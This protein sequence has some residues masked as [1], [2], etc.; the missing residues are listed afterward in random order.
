M[1]TK[2]VALAAVP[3]LFVALPL[4]ACGS[5]ASTSAPVGQSAPE[6]V[7][8]RTGDVESGTSSTDAGTAA[9]T[10]VDQQTRDVVRTAS[11]TVV[12][13][14]PQAAGDRI[15]QATRTAGGYVASVS[16]S[17]PDCG[18]TPCPTGAAEDSTGGSSGSSP[19][20]TSSD[21]TAEPGLLSMTVRVPAAK[22]DEVL[23][24]IRELG[25][26]AA[27]NVTADDVTAQTVDLDARIESQR[28]SVSRMRE[29]LR[30]ADTIDEM[31]RVEG[32]LAQRQADLES[33][34]SQRN[35]LADQ[36]AMAT[37]STELVAEDRAD[38]LLPP[39]P[40]W[41]DESWQAFTDSW[42]GLLVALAAVSPLLILFGIGAL[43][44]IAIIRHQ[45]G[46]TNAPPTSAEVADPEAPETPAEPVRSP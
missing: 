20:T 35:R 1:T 24:G 34:I 38:A 18:T 27:L 17:P 29:L 44:A 6:V 21:Q 8:P 33:M 41:W 12:V 3:L 45:R 31:V 39:D 25:E 37:I 22:Y 9:D 28:A 32:E 10:Q 23:T 7:D 19:G 36:V 40:H 30:Q 42:S 26:V 16:T 4:A 46:R 13:A 43:V 11:V 2:R 14:D 5:S 15:Q